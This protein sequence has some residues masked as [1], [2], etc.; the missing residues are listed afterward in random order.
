MTAVAT[1]PP[2]IE[3]RPIREQA[4]PSLDPAG[5][6]ALALLTVVTAIGLCR[7]FPDWA[8][9]RQMVAVVIGVHA[10]AA[11]LRYVR[12]P[13]WIALPVL[14][15]VAIE[16]LAIV[17][18]PETTRLLLPTGRTIEFLRADLRLVWQQFPSAVAPVPSEGS[19]AMASAALLS[20]CAVL[21]D[22]F[23]FRAFGRA[24]S[25]V[26]SGV[27]FV[28]TS[29]LGTDRNRVVVS[30]LW[31]GAAIV[32]IAVLRFG[33]AREESAW[34]GS[35]R[36]TLGS[37]LPASLACAA[38]AAL[39]AGVLAPRLPGAES[40]ALFD[41]RNRGGDV[42]EVLNPLVDIRSR[43]INRAN[44]EVFTVKASTGAYWREIGL[45]DFNGTQWQPLDSESLRS[46]D[47]ELAVSGDGQTIEQT[48][49]IKSLGGKLIP[50]AF[51]PVRTST[52]GL[53][54]GDVTQTLLKTDAGIERGDVFDVTSVRAN[55]T[56]DQLRLATVAGAPSA[57]LYDLPDSF[58][59]EAAELAREVTAAGANPY[60]KMVLLQN[61]FRTN[62]EYD[63]S[64]QAGSSDDAIRQFL[65]I[66][67]GY[68]EQFSGTF[69]AMARSLGIPARVAIGYTPGDFDAADGTW[70]VYDR[71]AHAWPEVWFDGFGWISFEPTPGRGEPGAEGHTGVTAAQ[72]DTAPVL[73]AGSGAETP[74][75]EAPVTTLANPGGTRPVD[76][77]S[78]AST[79]AP[80]TVPAT[81]GGS[82][83]DGPALW[84]LGVL[85]LIGAWVWF[86]PRIVRAAARRRVHSPTDRV[87]AAWRRSCDVLRLVGAP[88][89]GGATPI[90]YSRVV[91]EQ[92]GL[93]W[94]VFNELARTVTLA[95]YAPTGVDESTA[96][97]SEMLELQIDEICQPRIPVP[98][99]ILARLDP[100]VARQTG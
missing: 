52:P 73:G 13:I 54:F 11:V 92:V 24:E 41:T 15:L 85:A 97:R 72:D 21:A 25:V 6:V 79:V 55:P 91:E 3:V 42:T 22:T 57:A 29:A 18:Y 68:C 47:G 51:S 44:V 40:H 93:G 62:F 71:H 31:I 46:A 20:I 76:P 33:H 30:A 82:I 100:R 96:Q 88:A 8:Y 53:Y 35:R 81:D 36:R 61:W 12:L 74:L 27:V 26:P 56:P 17:Y 59:D 90:E 78:T 10:A 66:R 48:I 69:A 19:F 84:I 4:K 67:K 32:V 65:R 83:T 37:V 1:R 87:A 45:E 43:L 2:T 95:V 38:V 86:M 80:V 94:H 16:L 14:A 98:T 89:T 58:P 28:F 7:L 70:H 23:A 50:V 77:A 9:L 39:A 75:P 64:V 34:M 60:D 99:R 49:S 5:T 63:L